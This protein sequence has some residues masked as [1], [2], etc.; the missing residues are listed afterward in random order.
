MRTALLLLIAAVPLGSG[1]S[2]FI[3]QAGRDV[4]TTREQVREQFGQPIE[5]GAVDDKH[6]D[7]F[8]THRKLAEHDRASRM[9]MGIVMT[10]MVGELV[11]FPIELYTLTRRSVFGQDLRVWY[12]SNGAVTS[13]QID[14]ESLWLVGGS[15]EPPPKLD[16]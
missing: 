10:Y 7:Q 9:G 3:A 16:Q 2:V 5:S 4:G 12:D 11:A 14:G 13:V 6:F 15:N 1:C 8:R